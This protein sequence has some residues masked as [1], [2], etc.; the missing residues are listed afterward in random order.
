MCVCLCVG[1]LHCIGKS[2]QTDRQHVRSFV[3]PYL[4]IICVFVRAYVRACVRAGLHAC[5][6]ACIYVRMP[7]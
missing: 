1:E 7:G 2:G 4:C 6:H 5:M 3:F